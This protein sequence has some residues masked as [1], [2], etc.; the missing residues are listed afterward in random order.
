MSLSMVVLFS[1]LGSILYV[2]VLVLSYGFYLLGSLSLWVCIGV[3]IEVRMVRRDMVR[4]TISS[5]GH[6]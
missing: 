4:I 5:L 6:L 3:H 2:F 1:M